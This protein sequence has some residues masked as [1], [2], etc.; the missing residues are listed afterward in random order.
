MKNLKSNK[1]IT[2]VAL[3]IT[4]I[5]LLILAVVTISAVNEGNLFSHANNAATTY[6]EKA[7]EENSL[8]S[9]YI[10]EIKKYDKDKEF[11]PNK[12]IVGRTFYLLNQ[13]DGFEIP[14]LA[15]ITDDT[16]DAYTIFS[17]EYTTCRYQ[18][19]SSTKTLT[20]SEEGKSDRTLH[21]MKLENNML[22]YS[23]A[24]DAFSFTTTNGG[25]GTS[26]L[27]G[28]YATNGDETKTIQFEDNNNID[29]TNSVGQPSEVIKYYVAD[30]GTSS[31]GTYIMMLGWDLCEITKVGGVY[32]QIYNPQGGGTTY[33]LTPPQN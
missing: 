20:I 30:D 22:L 5:V 33:T 6:S 14:S 27:A 15:N 8:I 3:I 1:G 11:D 18:Y 25:E 16:L 28:Y 26:L 7:E 31:D 12:P 32:T 21:F 13:A 4:I 19:N 23:E 2:L 17:D 10:A 24:G 9:S 29:R